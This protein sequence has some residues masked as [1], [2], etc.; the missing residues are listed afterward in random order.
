MIPQA[1]KDVVDHASKL[2]NSSKV[3]TA[4]REALRNCNPPA[5]PYLGVYL[6]DLTKI[7]EGNS[8]LKSGLINFRKRELIANVLNEIR[9]Y[10]IST[11]SCDTDRNL[12]TLLCSLP[13]N[14]DEILYK[15]SLLR[16]PRESNKDNYNFQDSS[17]DP[18]DEETLLHSTEE[19]HEKEDQ[20]SDR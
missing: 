14:S 7:E 11:F 19:I 3:Y 18:S 8:D 4:Y 1:T 20:S 12:V 10:Q 16:E 2:F 5:V 13:R 17:T 15:M 9:L 6:T